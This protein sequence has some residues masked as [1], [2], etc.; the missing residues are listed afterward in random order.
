MKL[1][2]KDS[3]FLSSKGISEEE[4]ERQFQLLLKGTVYPNLYEGAETG[5]GIFTFDSVK[6]N[7][8]ELYETQCKNLTI[9]RFIPASGAA[10]RMF[11]H[12]QDYL[13]N[14][15]ESEL[16]DEFFNYRELFPFYSLMPDNI[17]NNKREFIDFILSEK[18]LN[19]SALPK[20]LIPFH[21]DDH[22]VYTAFQSQLAESLGYAIGKDNKAILHFT[23]GKEYLDLF[24]KQ[25]SEF[26]DREKIN[27]E[28]FSVSYSEQSSATDTIS[29]DE[30]NEPVRTPEGELLLRPGGHGS[31]IRNLNICTGDL[32]FIR[33][34]DNV[35]SPKANE[36]YA[37]VHKKL[38]GLLLFLRD[39]IYSLQ[40][41]ADQGISLEKEEVDFLKTYFF[42]DGDLSKDDLKK[43]LFRPLRVCGMVKNQGEPGG[44][45]FL[46]TE[47]NGSVSLQII[48]SAQVNNTDAHQLKIFKSGSYFNPVDLV[49]SVLN[50]KGEKYDL[51]DF[52]N[53]EFSFLAQ[54]KYMGKTIKVLEHPGLWN[55]AMH[56]WLTV[57]AEIPVSVFNPVKTVNDLL[58]SAHQK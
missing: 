33:N 17:R 11:S 15:T 24:R 43:F 30:N 28:L 9:L 38:G 10:S 57:F 4:A 12:L 41:K 39:K 7:V 27:P 49:C 52:V 26:Q 36:E 37:G 5:K 16:T 23:I 32:I 22:S 50:Y 40:K 31:L 19:Y 46:I 18:G 1:T 45:P 44:G 25:F 20:A 21:S 48:E 42:F 8:T 54:K 58:R 3:A 13:W 2:E 29:L 53:T 14:D 34:I 35:V 55:G 47:K 56:H 6:I 51:R